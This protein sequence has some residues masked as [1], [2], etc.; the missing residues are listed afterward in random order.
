[1]APLGAVDENFVSKSTLSD[2]LAWLSDKVLALSSGEHAAALILGGCRFSAL[3]LEASDE[4]AD[5]NIN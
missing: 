1:M 5:C 2:G 3:L 4:E